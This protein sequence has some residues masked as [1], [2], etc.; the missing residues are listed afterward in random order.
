MLPRP[1]SEGSFR[2]FFLNSLR[3]FSFNTQFIH[4][5]QDLEKRLEKA[6]RELNGIEGPAME[7]ADKVTCH[8]QR[9]HKKQEERKNKMSLY[10]QLM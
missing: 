7:L 8:Q 10:E 6:R 4:D 3:I 2:G 5:T 1:I 9:L